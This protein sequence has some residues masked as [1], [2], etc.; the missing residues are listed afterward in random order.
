MKRLGD[1]PF[2]GPGFA[3]LKGW[4]SSSADANDD[5]EDALQVYHKLETSPIFNSS[6]K[7]DVARTQTH[8]VKRCSYN[9]PANQL[10]P[11]AWLT[12][13]LKKIAHESTRKMGGVVLLRSEAGCTRQ[14]AHC[15]YVPFDD[16]LTAVTCPT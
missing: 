8:L 15:D 13:V 16:L 6:N 3:V 7:Q 11:T 12:N 9:K 1:L 4:S 14:M 10:E 5:V 2:N